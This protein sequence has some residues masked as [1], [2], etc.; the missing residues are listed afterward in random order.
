VQVRESYLNLVEES[1]RKNW[2][3]CQRDACKPLSDVDLTNCSLEIEYEAFSNNKVA[4]L[5]R[6]TLM[7]VVSKYLNCNRSFICFF[8]F[9]SET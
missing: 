4:S 7:K 6:R 2:E 9:R 3:L 5:Y 1:V 8:F